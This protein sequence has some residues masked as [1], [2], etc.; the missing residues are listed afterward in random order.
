V[1]YNALTHNSLVH[2]RSQTSDLNYLHRRYEL[3]PNTCA[4]DKTAAVSPPSSVR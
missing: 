3:R 4:R 2:F 1:S